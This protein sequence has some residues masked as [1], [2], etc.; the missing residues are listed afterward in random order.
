LIGNG[1]IIPGQVK[2]VVPGGFDL[3]DKITEQ[4]F[5]DWYNKEVRPNFHWEKRELICLFS[6]LNAWPKFLVPALDP[7]PIV[8]SSIKHPNENAERTSL[9]VSDDN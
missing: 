2:L 1:L 4:D 3:V 7:I 9:K 8:G 6:I 5:H